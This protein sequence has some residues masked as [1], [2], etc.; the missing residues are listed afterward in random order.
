MMEP[1]LS[2]IVETF[3]SHDQLVVESVALYGSQVNPEHVDFWS[4]IDLLMVLGQD[5]QLDA[6]WVEDILSSVGEILA[7]EV[8]V[9]PPQL[10]H[11]CVLEF[12]G[13]IKQVDLKLCKTSELN[14][15]IA[16]L[17]PIQIL[18]GKTDLT[19]AS[20][21]SPSV[22]P[23]SQVVPND[24]IDHLWFLFFQSIKKFMRED[25]LIGLHLLLEVLQEFLVLKMQERDR[26]YQTT[27]HRKGYQEKLPERLDFQHL[28]YHKKEAILTYLS[29]L[30]E[31]LD[32]ALSQEVDGYHSRN[33]VV[34]RYLKDSRIA[35]ANK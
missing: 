7:R 31:E 5:A 20:I 15:I 23:D 12:G 2:Q 18:V 11:R 13:A 21:S 9:N 17:G 4:D 14:S 6:N 3:L 19:E 33:T 30:A 35:L 26:K 28:L 10:T 1:F 32:R 8:F 27:I 25:R 16:Q 24:H 29:H 22:P 34:Q